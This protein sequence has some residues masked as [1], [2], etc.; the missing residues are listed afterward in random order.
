[1]QAIRNTTPRQVKFTKFLRITFSYRT[2]PVSV[3]DSFSFVACNFISKRLWQRYF[4]EIQI[5]QN[6][7]L[8]QHFWETAYFITSC[9]V[10]EFQPAVKNF[11]DAFQTFYKGTRSSLSKAFIY[12]ISVKII[13]EEANSRPVETVETGWSPPSHRILPNFIFI[14]WKK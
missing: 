13:C 4:S 10:A 9:Q 11:T 5:F 3:S 6:T 7:S 2:R 14:I 1:M 12:L 8:I